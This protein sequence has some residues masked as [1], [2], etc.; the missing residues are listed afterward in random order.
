MAL[1]AL[2]AIGAG[3]GAVSALTGGCL[4]A[5][6][7]SV[8]CSREQAIK[9]HNR[10]Q[11]SVKNTILNENMA[12]VRSETVVNA[13]IWVKNS[14][15]ACKRNVFSQ[16]VSG[17][18]KYVTQISQK[19][20]NDIKT[21]LK[22]KMKNAIEQLQGAQAAFIEKATNGKTKAEIITEL[23]QVIDNTIT[24]RN[25][26]KVLNAV[27][28]GEVMIFEGLEF[29]NADCEWI[30]TQDIALDVQTKVVV[31][32]LSKNIITS[33]VFTDIENYVKQKQE[34]A[35]KT[36]LIIAGIVVV[37]LVIGY[38]LLRRSNG[39]G[40]GAGTSPLIIVTPSGERS[41]ATATSSQT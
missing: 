23:S 22:S 8:G 20:E 16:T 30:V 3:V 2:A 15:S 39:G 21:D 25:L 1:L 34:G 36:F 32:Q 37:V 4:D 11:T 13:A 35:L 5:A 27:T 29:T 9:I 6:V 24:N 12:D 38:F 28:I 7:F 31:D 26:S 33:T 17:E 18:V 40:A 14:T 10:M 19:M 41:S